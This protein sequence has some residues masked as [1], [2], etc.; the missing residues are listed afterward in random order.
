MKNLQ[1]MCYI[2][3]TWENLHLDEIRTITMLTSACKIRT[4]SLYNLSSSDQVYIRVIIVEIF[5]A[6]LTS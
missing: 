5:I 3:L 4:R 2:L 6:L 1:T